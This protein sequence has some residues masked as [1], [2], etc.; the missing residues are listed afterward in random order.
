MEVPKFLKC[1]ECNEK[2]SDKKKRRII[3]SCGHPRCFSCLVLDNQCTVCET[4]LS[5]RKSWISRSR[6]SLSPTDNGKSNRG[7]T[8]ELFSKE[9]YL[10]MLYSYDPESPAARK[11]HDRKIKLGQH[12]SSALVLTNEISDSSLTLRKTDD[13]RR[14]S[15]DI[16]LSK[17]ALLSC[18][19]SLGK[20]KNENQRERMGGD[21]SQMISRRSSGYWS[22]IENYSDQ[23][24]VSSENSTQ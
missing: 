1:P 5:R 8:Y 3:D 17:I 4:I 2:Y 11:V 7:S 15:A 10:R 24:D 16:S 13:P 18:S 6:D 22:E 14:N 12:S 19:N 21:T 23:E 9:R 20:G